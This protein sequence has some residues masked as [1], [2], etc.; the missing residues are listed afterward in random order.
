MISFARCCPIPGSDFKKSISDSSIARAID[1]NGLFN[2]LNAARGPIPETV[3]NETV[4]RCM[5]CLEIRE[6]WLY[7]DYQ[8]GIGDLMLIETSSKDRKFEVIGYKKFE[9]MLLAGNEE[10]RLWIKRL[11]DLTDNLDMMASNPQDARVLQIKNVFYATARLVLALHSISK[12][13][14]IIS[15]D[16]L[17]LAEKAV[18]DF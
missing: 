3:I 9:S 12:K 2:A 13:R 1:D 5:Q 10:Q 7:R 11:S 15:K 16:T 18:K 14:N 8:A 17:K 4:A 6:A